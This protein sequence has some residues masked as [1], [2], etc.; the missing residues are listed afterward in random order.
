[1]KF[2][3][4]ICRAAP[5]AHTIT[6]QR[7][8]PALHAGQ[9]DYLLAVNQ[10]GLLTIV[11]TDDEAVV[12]QAQLSSKAAV[13]ALEVLKVHTS[14]H[15]LVCSVTA[16]AITVHMIACAGWVVTDV[17][18][19]PNAFASE[20]GQSDSDGCPARFSL[21][22][23]PEGAHLALLTTTGCVG[24]YYL[25]YDVVKPDT[26]AT[27]FEPDK[28]VAKSLSVV[29]QLGR[30]EVARLLG[31]ADF[32]AAGLEWQLQQAK[33]LPKHSLMTV[34]QALK[35]HKPAARGAYL[36]WRGSNRTVLY[37]FTD[38]MAKAAAGAAA[39]EVR[40]PGALA[41][42]TFPLNVTCS[43]RN[44]SGALVAF[45][46][47]D[48]S[49]TVLDT[50]LGNYRAVLPR[51]PTPASAL[52]F[53]CTD[54]EETVLAACGPVL[55]ALSIVEGVPRKWVHRTL[56]MSIHAIV[57]IFGGTLVLL[58]CTNAEFRGD[59]HGASAAHAHVHAPA[60]STSGS[61]SEA[62]AAYKP[63][64]LCWYDIRQE[65]LISELRLP[66]GWKA[67]HAP[68]GNA[69]T[70]YTHGIGTAC[71]SG[72]AGA[73]GGSGAASTNVHLFSFKSLAR[74]VT[75]VLGR[76]PSYNLFAEMSME[77]IADRKRAAIEAAAR[78]KQEAMSKL[79]GG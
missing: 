53:W 8:P 6:T 79:P 69:L 76:E 32:G 64:R 23:S 5:T 52:G 44:A 21:L 40:D 9:D 43:G 48:G 30:P 61:G 2:S 50:Q 15:L 26:F 65:K 17:L 71:V 63:T 55:C 24:L 56:P 77:S 72:S 31:H 68:E 38:F 27:R 51:L 57:H 42:Y 33:P 66:A 60:A 78:A 4:N 47:S 34:E 58:Q 45:C 37:A 73:G 20:V 3:F 54:S 28:Y 67:Q 19:V 14:D 22:T 35:K 10:E 7:T 74:Q 62:P 18:T 11:N 49:V 25:H 46:M 36:W 70:R 1:M 13:V 75:Q 59:Q 39:A 12:S 29:A 41:Q 16:A